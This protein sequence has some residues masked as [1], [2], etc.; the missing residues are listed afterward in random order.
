MSFFMEV[1]NR[2]NKAILPSP[3]HGITSKNTLLVTYQGSRSGK[4]YTVPVNYTQE[5]NTVRITSFPQRKWW[6][7]LRTN[8]EVQLTIRGKVKMGSAQVYDD[9]E[10]TAKEL[11]AYLLPKKNMAKYFQ[12]GVSPDGSLNQQ[13]LHQAAKNRVV[14]KIELDE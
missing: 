11:K 12:V 14:I 5:G 13:D 7:S 9:A 8:P 1:W 10:N 3:L 2:F 6:R 4:E